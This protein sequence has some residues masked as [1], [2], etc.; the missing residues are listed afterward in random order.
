MSEMKAGPELDAR[1]CRLLE[2]KPTAQS[3]FW[4]Q[5]VFAWRPVPV[6]TDWDATGKAIEV[7]GADYDI[8]MEHAPREYGRPAFVRLTSTRY[9]QGA[10]TSDDLKHAFAL[11]AVKALEKRAEAESA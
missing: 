8:T 6:S 4:R 2:P 10:A 1:L 9:Q 11:A 5:H 7:L 3:T